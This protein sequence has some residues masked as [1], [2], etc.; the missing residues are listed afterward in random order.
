VSWQAQLRN[1]GY[2]QIPGLVPSHL[3]TA[4]LAAIRFDLQHHYDAGRQSEYDAQSYCPDLRG[5]AVIT[6]LLVKSPVINILDEAFG[7]RKISWDGG[8]IAIR[9]AH[10]V[11]STMPPYPHLDGFASGQNGLE[12]GRIY[13]HTMLVG[14]C[15]TPVHQDFAGNF[16]VWP[17]S[18]HV[19]ENYFRERGQQALKEPMPEPEIGNPV[20]LKCEAGDV[21]L[22]HYHLAHAAA[23]NTSNADRI[24]IY[25]RVSLHQ[26]R[27]EQWKYLTH[28]WEGWKI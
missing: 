27:A 18:H 3:V 8:Q 1:E 4:A 2:A 28:L 6:D 7:L 11:T 26:A 15:L 20:Q 21:V 17:R 12:P 13:N 9:K 24:A 16:T 19:F 5:A 14:I 22:A 23:S 25:F 10:N